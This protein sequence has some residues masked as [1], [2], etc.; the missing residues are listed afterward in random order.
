MSLATPT[1]EDLE[2]LLLSARYGDV[3]DIQQFVDKF[4]SDA[5][6]TVRDDSGNTVLHMVAGNGHTDALNFLLPLVPSSL[7]AARN[8][9]GSTALHW[10]ALNAHLDVAKKL[11]RFPGGPGV[12]LID[13]KNATGRSP[14]GEAEN[15]GWEEG[16]RW[17]VQVM[18]LDEN[19]KSEAV[20]EELQS[21]EGVDRVEVE[22]QD[23]EGQVAKTVFG[24]NET[25]SKSVCAGAR[26]EKT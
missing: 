6:A 24:T 21:A 5:F 1:S 9:A 15:A 18:N 8:N 23:A 26:A 10:A 17:F 11:V 7:L 22:I 13:I 16:A 4:G 19:A 12:D 14:L 2:E 3:D 25:D 20:D